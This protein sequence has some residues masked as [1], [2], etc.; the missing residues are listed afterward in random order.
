MKKVSFGIVN[1]NRL[2]Y[3]KS[4]LESLLDTTD[5]YKEK[6]I[7][8]VDNASVEKGTAE[9]LENLE[10]RGLTVV[11]K[12]NRN[13][14]N[15]FAIG[16]NTIISRAS[17]DY[18]CLLQ[19][20]MQFILPGWLQDVVGFY[21]KNVDV[22]GSVMLDAQRRI[23]HN[24]H[25]IIRF[26]DDRHPTFC[27]NTFFADFSRDPISP[28]ADAVF[29]RKVIEQIA[30][31]CE[32]NKNHEGSMDSENEMRYRILDM[33]KKQQI[34][35]YV[36]ALSSVPQSIAIYTDSRGTQGRVRDNKR[37]GDYW[38]A[39]DSTGWKYYEYITEQEFLK[40]TINSIEDVARPIGFSKLLDKNGDWL[41]NPIRPETALE[42][43][44]VDL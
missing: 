14:A 19:G 10:A 25:K 29:S 1:C 8:I 4:C 20:D 44:Y 28:A 23:T 40:D 31:W 2:F 26:S 43:D 5:D 27:K 6:E 16:L 11:R 15:E 38:Q 13:P 24:S 12:N 18:L 21:E 35:R 39:K 3:L 37:Y 41:K 17:G 33:M 22:V 36:T 34:P 32:D 7:I 9:Y 30:P 42:T